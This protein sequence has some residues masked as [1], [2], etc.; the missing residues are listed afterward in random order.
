MNKFIL[1]CHVSGQF[2]DS[3]TSLAIEAIVEEKLAKGADLDDF[4]VYTATPAMLLPQDKTI[5][6]VNFC[7]NISTSEAT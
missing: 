4:S 2:W 5:K 7:A 3:Y 1:H 6:G